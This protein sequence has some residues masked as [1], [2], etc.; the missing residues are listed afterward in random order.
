M[1]KEIIYTENYALIVDDSTLTE[2]PKNINVYSRRYKKE[3]RFAEVENSYMNEC[4]EILFHLPLNGRKKLEGVPL[5]P[6]IQYQFTEE[7]MRLCFEESRSWIAQ[8][9]EDFIQSLQQSKRPKFFEFEMENPSSSFG[10][11][12]ANFFG[13]R[14]PKTELI[15]GKITAVG[16]YKY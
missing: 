16:T 8:I 15:N 9:F 3:I 11:H 5:L 2:M 6:E 13:E 14:I 12:M 7:D 4:S 10:A 1:T